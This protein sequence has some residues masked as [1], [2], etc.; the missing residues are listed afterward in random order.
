VSFRK[1]IAEGLSSRR[2]SLFPVV[3]K[4]NEERHREREKFRVGAKTMVRV[5]AA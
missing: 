3:G 1:E 4:N 5:S 2:K